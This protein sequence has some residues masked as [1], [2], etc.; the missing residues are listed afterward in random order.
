MNQSLVLIRETL[1]KIPEGEIRCAAV[2]IPPNTEALSAV[3]APRGEMVHYIL[4]GEEN[5][6][7]RWKIK[8]ATFSNLQAIP[9]MLR[10]T[11]I[12]DARISINSIDPCFSCIEH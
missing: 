5:R 9:V 3:E 4:T 8:T 10:G 11:N 6:P 7:L 1:E 2:E 12:A